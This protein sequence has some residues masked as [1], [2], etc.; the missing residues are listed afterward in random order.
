MK[1]IKLFA[2]IS[3]ICL[4]LAVFCFG[5]FSATQVTYTIGGSIS[6]EVTDVFANVKTRV[7]TSN[8]NDK[9]NLSSTVNTIA[10]TGDVS[11]F[12]DTNYEYDFTTNGESQSFDNTENGTKEGINIEYNTKEKRTYFV[13]VSIKNN[14]DNTISANV[15]GKG[16]NDGANTTFAKSGSIASLTKT[17]NEKRLVLAFMLDDITIG[18]SGRVSFEYVI[19]ISNGIE[20]EKFATISYLNLPK[21]E[22]STEFTIEKTEDISEQSYV[23]SNCLVNNLAGAGSSQ[24]EYLLNYSL[25]NVNTNLFNTLKINVEQTADASGESGTSNLML[26]MK[27]L[28]VNGVS[29]VMNNFEQ[30]IDGTTQKQDETMGIIEADFKDNG[31]HVTVNQKHPQATLSYKYQLPTD[32]KIDTINFAMYIV[33]GSKDPKGSITLSFINVTPPEEDD[34]FR[35]TKKDDNT[36]KISAKDNTTL[37]GDVV[38]PDEYKGIPVTEIESTNPN[39]SFK[40]KEDDKDS[41]DTMMVSYIHSQSYKTENQFSIKNNTGFLMSDI[42]SLT[43][44]KNIEIIGTFAFASNTGMTSLKFKDGSKL[45]E[46]QA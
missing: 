14:G 26:T 42:S 16:L 8:F 43:I 11:N 9:N 30:N 1:K 5:V 44:G 24:R 39:K 21:E 13:V 38:I 29:D 32:K 41:Y 7:Y 28:T 12:T 2:T 45:K 27:N 6:Y 20:K 34:L 18:I 40:L 22:T 3:T 31:G 4:A 37:A 25:S 35:Y 10:Q 17:E 23:I 36:W 33:T 19:N 46:I 15:T